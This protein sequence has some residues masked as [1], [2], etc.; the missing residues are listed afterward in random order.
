M[1][2]L[3][4]MKLHKIEAGTF[5][6]DGGAIFGVVPKNVWQKRYPCDEE[7]FC[8]LTMRCLFIDTGEKKI[9]I[10]TGTGSKQLAYLK[11]YGFE[12][13]PNLDL[14]LQ[15]IGYSAA[16]ITDVVLTHL[17]FDHCGGCTEFAS[18]GK[19]INI[20][21]PNATHWVGK[22]QWENFKAPN[23]R[24]GDSY[25]PEN[26][27]PIELAGKLRLVT[28]N[29]WLC[30]ELELRIFD[31]HTA[32]QLV[33]YIHHKNNTYVYVGDVIP[34]AASLPIAW[35]SAYDTNPIKSM[36]EKT[37]LLQEAV[38][39]N[40]ILIFEHDFYNECCTIKEVN[41][42]YKLSESFTL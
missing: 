5:H 25:F 29:E 27:L 9:L 11:Y 35:I 4:S 16:E 14:E 23:I 17:H 2:E 15:K 28:E 13:I 40:Q 37:V 39:K 7:N 18:D 21:F 22:T 42:R 41:G 12:K 30:K 3:K 34:V 32:G 1:K 20:S 36:V 33:A 6:V 26:M 10:D 8:I 31:G 19:S 38:E 24:E